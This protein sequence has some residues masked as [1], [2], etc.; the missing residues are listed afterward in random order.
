MLITEEGALAGERP[1][2]RRR[3][4]EEKERERPSRRGP[5]R[6]PG[7]VVAAQ[8]TPDETSTRRA[9]PKKRREV[10]GT[11]AKAPARPLLA[12]AYS[13]YEPYEAKIT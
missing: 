4:E 10:D 3:K 2:S 6:G 13:T 12:G 1:A 8:A 7:G 9:R 5:L 11:A